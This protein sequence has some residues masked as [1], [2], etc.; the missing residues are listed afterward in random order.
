MLIDL[1]NSFEIDHASCVD[2]AH[3]KM[4]VDNYDV[5]ISDYEMPQK[6]GL[7]FLA[8]LREQKN[9]TPFILFTDTSRKEV[10]IKALN[11]GADAYI[12][13][14]GNPQ[15]VYGE[16]KHALVKT[17]E[18]KESLKLLFGSEKKY[19][20]LVDSSLQGMAVVQ[21]PS[22]R[23]V[24]ANSALGRIIGIPAE[25]LINLSPEEIENGIHP[26]DREAFFNRFRKRLQGEKVESCFK[27][28]GIQK[29]GSI[30]WVEACANLIEYDKKP[31]VQ[32]LFLDITERK[33]AEEALI[34]SEER[35]RDLADSLPEIVFETDLNGKVTYANKNAFTMT[36]YTKEDLAKGTCVFDLIEEKDRE[37][38]KEHFNRILANQ[39][40]ARDEY[41][42]VKKDG[43]SFPIMIV[44]KP[45]MDGK[46]IV[47]LR[48]IAIDITQRKQVEEALL[49]S[50]KKSRAIVAN[51]LIGIA[52][53]GADKNFLSANE[54]FCKILG[55]SE[56]ELQKLSFKDITHPGDLK[57]SIIKL[58]EVQNGLTSS[59]VL[60]K[61]YIKKDGTVI[62]GRIMV[63]AVR[64]EK[65]NP[66]LFIAELEDTTERKKADLQRKVLEKKLKT[67]SEHLKWLVDLRTAQLKDANNQLVKTE[68]F[69][70]IGELAGM[71][72]HDL[73]NPLASI[74]NATY[75]LKKKG[76][77]ISETQYKEFLEIIDKSIDHSDKI[78][79]DL[80]EYSREMN[81][82]L[83]KFD[84]FILVDSA[85]QMVKVP[86]RI[87]IINNVQ[88]EISIW[89]NADKM[90]RV[91][92]NLIKNA[93]DAMPQ[94]GTLEISC[95]Q[96]QDSIEISFT[97]TGSGITKETLQKLFTPLF[98]TK[99][100]GMGFGLAIC[101]RIVEAHGGTIKVKTAI[102]I[103]TT[104]IIT[105][106]TQ[107]TKH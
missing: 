43:S 64:N 92:A 63:S 58:G 70:A 73:R 7:Q 39:L 32:I 100:Q 95:C 19:R 79:N 74:K 98:T 99:A 68:R 38:S 1:E 89:I 40:S 59:F 31:A 46:R 4:A 49:E 87:K 65:G 104:F 20:S 28:R 44:S 48:G 33:K 10:A 18:R 106:P 16:L 88:K 41:T 12:D 29:D 56:E 30:K 53:S 80:L 78:I 102:N 27:Y 97:D 107:I 34:R 21:G 13:K 62:N 105:I 66:N 67:Y 23:L 26:D 101:K 61:R 6:D 17:V 5:I 83:S 37:N 54:A 76:K 93:V 86:D 71:V 11:L 22:P 60:E 96:T 36:R 91:F 84:A 69:A 55:Y 3:R 2:Q 85:L 42:F 50:E 14:Q 94:E 103:G 15:T 72:G 47:G 24:F 45:I 25:E 75:F 9:E 35:Y 90:M 52:T 77:T 81:L 57:E 51:S 82:E 8:E